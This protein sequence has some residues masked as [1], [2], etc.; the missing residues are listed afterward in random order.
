MK[1]RP[2][3]PHGP[4]PRAPRGAFTL[5]EL[6]VVIAIIAVLIGLLL[7]AVQKVRE[8]ANRTKCANNL[9]QIGLAMHNF[10]DTHNFF[11]P[12]RIRDRY[13]SWATL[14]LPYIEQANL[15]NQWDITREYYQQPAS[16]VQAQVPTY[17]C[18][19]R[20]SPPQLSLN[21]ANGDV[22]D[23]GGRA[24]PGGLA[25]YAVSTLSSDPNGVYG[26][27]NNMAPGAIIDGHENSV[28]AGG[29]ITSWKG[30]TTIASIT[31]GTSNTL[32]VGEKHVRNDRFGNR[33]NMAD[34]SIYGGDQAQCIARS[35][36]PGRQLAL[37][38]SSSQNLFGSYHP[39]VCQFVFCDGSVRALPVGLSGDILRRLVWRHEGEV[40]PNF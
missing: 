29:R 27:Y 21:D 34:C 12:Y 1:S 38:T 17:Y 14:I 35:A 37:L 3:R 39:G 16:V 30:L 11:P 2:C 22:R 7:P 5:I 31:D 26:S 19:T 8:A 13:A 33:P 4:S 20:R 40:I 28:L 24:F 6:L 25:D 9:K 32:L 23:S 10:H 36:G 15:Y 18:P